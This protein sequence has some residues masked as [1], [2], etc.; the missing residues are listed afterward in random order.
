MENGMTDDEK[1]ISGKSI[2]QSVLNLTSVNDAEDKK[3]SSVWNQV[4]SK[5]G[6]N[7]NSSEDEKNCDITLGERMAMNS[8]VVDFKKGILLVETKHS[9]WIQYFRMY[10][11]FIIKGLN[12]ALPNLQIK[13][14][15]FRLEG[16]NAKLSDNYDDVYKKAKA[17]M[18]RKIENQEEELNKKFNF[19]ES[20]KKE[21]AKNEDLPPEFYEMFDKLTKSVESAEQNND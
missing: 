14:L 21:N 9:G 13:S 18:D 3:I 12:W 10:Q 1:I 4:V 11:N 15:G 6:S 16:S 19:S 7:K 8:R 20:S 5:I 17:E 2:F